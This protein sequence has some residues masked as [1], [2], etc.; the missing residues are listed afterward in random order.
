M[1][2]VL[3]PIAVV[4][5]NDQIL[6]RKM[7]PEKSPYDELWA[8]FGGRIDNLDKDIIDTLNT[9]LRNRWNFTVNMKEKLWWDQET[10][11]DNDSETKRFIY[12]DMLCELATGTPQS[13]D[14]KEE[15]EW[16]DTV[17]LAEYDLNPPTKLLLGRMGII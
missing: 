10:K 13:T 3:M 15:I 4:R 7:N 6:L 1:Q 11:P 2:T 14:E 16:V 5:Q 17:K 9:D 8:L 12:L